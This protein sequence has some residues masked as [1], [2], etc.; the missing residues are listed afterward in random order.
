MG[1]G[2]IPGGLGKAERSHRI[3]EVVGKQAHV[4]PGQCRVHGLD[5]VV[6][7]EAQTEVPHQVGL[8]RRQTYL[9]QIALDDA[10]GNRH[11]PPLPP[12]AQLIRGFASTQRQ[13]LRLRLR[14][15]PQHGA[16]HVVNRHRGR[17]IVLMHQKV[18]PFAHTAHLR[19]NSNSSKTASII[20]TAACL[21]QGRSF[22]VM[23]ARNGIRWGV[24][25]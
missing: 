21:T 13:Q 12:S 9:L 4:R 19:S 1:N 3:P 11:G 6:I 2:Q 8:G 24:P 23:M 18:G 14:R 5:P 7:A 20:R 17:R 16:G 22:S 25:P 15:D 10:L